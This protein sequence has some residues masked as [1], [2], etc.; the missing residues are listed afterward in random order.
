MDISKIR[1]KNWKILIRFFE[2]SLSK[3]TNFF[4]KND[5]NFPHDFGFFQ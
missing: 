2:N 3:S 5:V 4:R 1:K